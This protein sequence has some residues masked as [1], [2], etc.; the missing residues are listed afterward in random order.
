MSTKSLIKKCIENLQS[1]GYV[2]PDK[3][4]FYKDRNGNVG[5]KV[6]EYIHSCHVDTTDIL[7]LLIGINTE[8]RDP[9][10]REIWNYGFEKI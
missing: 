6:G 3:A 10:I 9:Y 5:M 8:N 2:I 7:I 4:E 1:K